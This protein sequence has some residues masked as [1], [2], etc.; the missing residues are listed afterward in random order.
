MRNVAREIGAWD[1]L[2]MGAAHEGIRGPISST[3][4]SIWWESYEA[5]INHM[6]NPPP[7]LN[8]L[9]LINPSFSFVIQTSVKSILCTSQAFLP[10]ANKSTGAYVYALTSGAL[11]FPVSLLPGQSAYQSA[12]VAQVKVIEYLASENPDIFFCTVHPGMGGYGGSSCVG[13]GCGE[14]TVGYCCSAG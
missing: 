9:K 2:I 4:I 1:V 5:I 11:V 6:I 10:F 7:K 13:C 8:F 3:D 14:I 12:Q